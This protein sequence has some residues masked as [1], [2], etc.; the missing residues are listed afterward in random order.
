MAIPRKE[1]KIDDF[2]QAAEATRADQGQPRKVAK[3]APDDMCKFLL[4][5]PKA[6]RKKLNL[7]AKEKDFQNVSQYICAILANRKKI[8]L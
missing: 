1:K 4:E 8:E 7:E 6:L 2:I 3:A 5:L